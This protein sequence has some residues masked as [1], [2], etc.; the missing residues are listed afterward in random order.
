MPAMVALRFT[1]TLRVLAERLMAGGKHKRLV[2][3]AP[4]RKVLVFAY[5]ILMV[6]HRF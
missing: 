4:M 3:G 5:G 6:R 1:P 2:I